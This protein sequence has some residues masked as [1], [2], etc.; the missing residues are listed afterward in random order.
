MNKGF[1]L[2]ELLIAISIIAILAALGLSAYQ[3][4]YKSSRDAKRESDLK[5]IQSALEDFHADNLYYPFAVTPGNP[6]SSGGK[7]YL[8]KVPNDPLT[9]NPIYNYVA[10]GTNC[11]ENTPKNCN[12]Y[13]LSA[14]MEV[15]PS[16]IQAC[17]SAGRNYG[18]T[19]P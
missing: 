16:G 11:A 9:G 19:R 8:T 14:A 7:I 17:T 18:V 2:V 6:L 3:S 1:T 10:S 13:C 5:L 12:S 15:A 4:V